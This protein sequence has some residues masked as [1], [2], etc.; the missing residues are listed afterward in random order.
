MT[1]EISKTSK[2]ASKKAE[3]NEETPFRL[4]EELQTVGINMSDIKKLQEYG[5]MTIG[6]ILQCSSRDLT[7]I[8]GMSDAKVDKIKEAAKKLDCRGP[9]FKTGKLSL[10]SVCEKI[11]GFRSG[12]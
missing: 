9:I 2:S 11:T 1:S 6:S 3:N 10:V 12:G 4:V 5:L 7:S 8:K